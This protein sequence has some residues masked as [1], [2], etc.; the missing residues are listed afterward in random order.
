M[1]CTLDVIKK[2]TDH[3]ADKTRSLE[4]ILA[5]LNAPIAPNPERQ[6]N[7]K[8]PLTFSALVASISSASL[9]KVILYDHLDVVIK[10][11][12]S[13]DYD[14]ANIWVQGFVAAGIL[15]ADD[16]IAIAGVLTA[17]V[18]DPTYKPQLSWAEINLGDVLTAQ[19]IKDCATLGKWPT[20]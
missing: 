2:V 7:V 12:R 16:A 19:D 1:N 17:A 3:V 13:G 15:T 5:E 18:P 8:P 6:A 4:D 10:D 14:A 20:A 11:L 9:G